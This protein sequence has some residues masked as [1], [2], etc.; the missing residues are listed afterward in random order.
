[1]HP[2]AGD[3]LGNRHAR[4]TTAAREGITP[5]LID[6]IGDFVVTAF[7]SRNSNQLGFVFT[8]H[9]AI[10]RRILGITFANLYTR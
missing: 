3:A 9:D 8:K 7:A 6:T 5:N 10:F 1:M 2:D 4:Q